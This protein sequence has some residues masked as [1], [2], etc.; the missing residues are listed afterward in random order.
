MRMRT[1]RSSIY[2]IALKL[3][4]AISHVVLGRPLTMGSLR[5]DSTCKT[6]AFLTTILVALVLLIIGP[7]STTAGSEEAAET[8]KRPRGKIR[9]GGIQMSG[10]PSAW[11]ENANK[12]ERMIREAARVGAQ[13]VLTPELA[14]SGYPSPPKDQ[15]ELVRIHQTA[16]GVPGPTSERFCSLAEELGIYVLLGMPTKRNERLYNSVLVIAPDGEILWIFDKVHINKYELDIQYTNGSEFPVREVKIGD[17]VCRIGVM[18]CYDREIP[19]SARIL[20]LKGADIIFLPLATNCPGREIHRDL[21]RVRAFENEVYVIMVN[22][23]S[24]RMNGLSM[25]VDPQGNLFGAGMNDEEVLI[26]DVDLGL[27]DQVRS[28]GIY[29]FHHRR[30]ELYGIIADPSYAEPVPLA[31]PVAEPDKQ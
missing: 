21:I 20:M 15:E 24:P 27:L 17:Q 14:L 3:V 8:M 7:M 6:Y 4:Q 13:I 29:G 25:F 19:E 10:T 1:S 12:A 31:E 26:A 28:R 5:T 30:P 2:P 18:I 11:E 22:Q 9:V 16:E 23:A